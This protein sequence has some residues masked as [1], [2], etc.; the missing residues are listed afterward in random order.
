MWLV[1]ECWHMPCGLC[2]SI[3]PPWG[4]GRKIPPYHT[5]AWAVGSSKSAKELYH[6]RSYAWAELWLQNYASPDWAGGG[7]V[8]IEASEANRSASQP[9]SWAHSAS[10]S[11]SQASGCSG[12]LQEGN[13]KQTVG[14]QFSPRCPPAGH[15][16]LKWSSQPTNFSKSVERFVSM[17]ALDDP[18]KILFQLPSRNI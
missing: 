15:K 18:E 8:Q 1:G 17:S 7:K 3:I 5:A 14:V 6:V 9:G 12:S 4:L 2:E 11:W 13:F 10:E 16:H